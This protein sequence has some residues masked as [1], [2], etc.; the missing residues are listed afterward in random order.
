[1]KWRIALMAAWM[2]A[3]WMSAPGPACAL[4]A[5]PPAAEFHNGQWQ[6]VEP[7]AAPTA[8]PATPDPALDHVEQLLSAGSAKAAE[9]LAISW[10][11]SHSK[12]APQRDRAIYL[13]GVATYQLD[14]FQGWIRAFYYCD[15]VM[16]E[17]P[18]SPLFNPS[19]AL[20]YRIADELL[21]GHR[22]PFLGIPLVTA[23]DEAVEMLYRIQQRSPGSP[24]AERALL[25]TAD[26]YYANRDYDLAQDAY[27]RYV[28]DY[29]RSPRVPAVRLR[30]AFASLA[31]FRGV[32]F[33]PSMILDARAQLLDLMAA[34][35]KLAQEENLAALVQAVDD[36]LSEKLYVTADFYRRTKLPASA[37]YLYRYL[38]AAYPASPQAP[39]ARAALAAMPPWATDQPGPQVAAS[40]LPQREGSATPR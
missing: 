29:P 13:L 1:M 3:A 20:Q 16:D 19:L 37:V 22:M 2:A 14:R 31:Q 23:Y 15:E 10:I 8:S 33:D 17:Y 4:A 11:K 39:A 25:R 12:T 6:P 28:K 30:E 32:R 9:T 38:L 40:Y 21:N 24:L 18:N 5:D 27:A 7:A 35:P 26:Y 36:T 34:Y